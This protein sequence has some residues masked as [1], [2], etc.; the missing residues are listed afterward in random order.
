MRGRR[1]AIGEGGEAAR[2]GARRQRQDQA[3]R[4]VLTVE[5]ELAVR[6]DLDRIGAQID[7]TVV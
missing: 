3:A 1:A 5:G 7:L 2:P 4:A 6:G